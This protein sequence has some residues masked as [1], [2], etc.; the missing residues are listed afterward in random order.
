MELGSDTRAYPGGNEF[1]W[2]GAY[3]RASAHP[4]HRCWSFNWGGK[5]EMWRQRT[6]Y[7]RATKCDLPQQF[8][9]RLTV[10]IYNNLKGAGEEAERSIRSFLFV[11]DHNLAIKWIWCNVIRFL[12]F[13]FFL[14]CCHF[15]RQRKLLHMLH[16]SS[17]AWA[18]PGWSQEPWTSSAFPTRLAWIQMHEI[19]PAASQALR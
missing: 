13:S 10:M 12:V 6:R 2:A 7:Q 15:E 18:R 14:I 4:D 5:P 17:Y 19:L 8:S 11:F 9:K 16:H 3:I 1:V